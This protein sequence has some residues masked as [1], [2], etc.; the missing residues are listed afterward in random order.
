MNGTGQLGVA[1]FDA[2]YSESALPAKQ[3]VG[4]V[5]AVNNEVA[6]I[7]LVVVE[8]S[9]APNVRTLKNCQ[10]EGKE[11]IRRKS[12]W[13]QGQCSA[14]EVLEAKLKWG[15]RMPQSAY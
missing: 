10:V 15:G 7:Q 5:L 1:A 6:V 3:V 9:M 2:G 13:E 12:R 8:Y 11:G 4:V 14:D